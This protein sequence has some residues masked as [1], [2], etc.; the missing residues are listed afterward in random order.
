MTHG[1]TDIKFHEI[2]YFIVSRNSDKKTPHL[3][4]IWQEYRVL[5]IRTNI[6]LWSS[7]SES[8]WEWKI[9]QTKFVEKVKAH[10][11]YSVT[12]F[13]WKRAVCEIMWKN[14]VKPDSPEMTIMLI[15]IACWI[16]NA[17][18]IH[19]EYEILNALPPLQLL[20]ERASI[21]CYTYVTCLSFSHYHTNWRI[22]GKA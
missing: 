6:H 3:I 1:H 13:F 12:F 4:E 19:S 5:Y 10:I 18:N 11:L 8:L 21:L 9:C 22:F 16:T 2:F 15:R 17:T 7:L 20:H 14:T